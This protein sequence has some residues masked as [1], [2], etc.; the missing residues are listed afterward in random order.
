MLLRYTLSRSSMRIFLI[1]TMV[2]CL[3][4]VLACT[5][6]AEPPKLA[7]NNAAPAKAA[8]THG[9]DH[10]DAPRI[11]L[12]E[13]KK[14]FDAG[15]AVFIDTRGADGYKQEHVKGAINIAAGDIAAKAD[16]IPKG[17]KIIAYCS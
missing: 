8:D 3:A 9:D 16:T 11:T 13:A 10:D 4:F 17:K 5:N 7:A 15:N 14:D 2:A 1:T 12:A 6:A